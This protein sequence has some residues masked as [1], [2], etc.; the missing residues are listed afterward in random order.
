MGLF[1]E[2]ASFSSLQNQKRYETNGSN[3]ANC[4]PVA[5]WGRKL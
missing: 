1:H 2:R 5:I 4:N 3:Q